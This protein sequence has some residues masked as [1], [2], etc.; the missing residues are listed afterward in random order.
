MGKYGRKLKKP[1]WITVGLGLAQYISRAFMSGGLFVDGWSLWLL[2][3]ALGIALTL[4]VQEALDRKTWLGRHVFRLF[5][6]LFEIEFAHVITADDGRNEAVN[7]KVRFTR[8]LRAVTLVV[9]AYSCTQ[10]RV[11]PKQVII[12]RRELGFQTKG[13]SQLVQVA[14]ITA[15]QMTWGGGR[16]YGAGDYS[17][18]EYGRGNALIR[19]SHNVVEV[20]ARAGWLPPQRHRFYLQVAD[21]DMSAKRRAFLIDEEAALF[22][23]EPNPDDTAASW[24]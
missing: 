8:A 2:C 12:A 9:R 20:E 24:S 1:L 22:D 13:S 14:T 16:P 10:R 3:G 19:N 23:T 7:L 17:T 4:S 11:P 6:Q 5:W 18:D 15:E 21:N